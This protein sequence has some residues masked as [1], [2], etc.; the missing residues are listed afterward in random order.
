MERLK[1]RSYDS[2]GANIFFWRTWDKME[3]DLIEE[4]EGKLFGYEFKWSKNKK[5]KTADF[6]LETYPEA[7]VETITSDN[8]IDFII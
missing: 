4:R 1:K 8:F 2:I 5:S 3:I 7:S 6:F